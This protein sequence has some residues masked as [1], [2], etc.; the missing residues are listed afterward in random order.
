MPTPTQSSAPCPCQSGAGYDAC[1]GRLHR[2]KAEA[3]T[4]E[5]L[6]RSRYSAFAVGDRTYLLKTWSSETRPRGLELD[7]GQEWTG[8][9]ILRV[10]K[11]GAEDR[12]GTVEFRARF[13]T[14]GIE[15]QQQEVSTFVREDGRWVYREALS[16]R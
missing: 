6:M 12:V 10:A 16:L 2:G 1:C 11:G 14:G 4:A 15:H 13:R 7:P 3:A 5:E 9:E 8:L